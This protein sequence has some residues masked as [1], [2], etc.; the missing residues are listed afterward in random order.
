LQKQYEPAGVA[1]TPIGVV[2]TARTDTVVIVVRDA[3]ATLRDCLAALD[4]CAGVIVFDNGSTDGSPEIAA[5]VRRADVAD[6]FRSSRRA[7]QQSAKPYAGLA[8]AAESGSGGKP[9]G[10][11]PPGAS[12][13]V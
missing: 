5:S 12:S 4:F 6:P 8:V 13:A 10:G 9:P 7:R 11:S 3:A 1:G 2:M